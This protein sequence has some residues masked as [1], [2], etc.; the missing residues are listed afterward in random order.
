MVNKTGG[1]WGGRGGFLEETALEE[2][3]RVT[4]ALGSCDLGEGRCLR[5]WWSQSIDTRQIQG[6]EF[7]GNLMERIYMGNN[8]WEGIGEKYVQVCS[9]LC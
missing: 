6:K 1:A 4:M 3:G 5:G 8:V 2:E 9:V 7:S